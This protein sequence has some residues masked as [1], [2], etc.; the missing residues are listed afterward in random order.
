MFEEFSD[1]AQIWIYGFEEEL[2]AK[3]LKIVENELKNFLEHWKS[4]K[5][6][7]KGDFEILLSRFV[8]LVAES[9]VS[10]C[11]IDKSVSVFKKLRQEHQLNALNQ[12]LVY[13]RN[14]DSVSALSR[15]A[16]QKFV[17][18]DK[19]SWDTIVYN[20]T[21]VMLGVFREGQWELPF[22]KSWHGQ[23]FKKSA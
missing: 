12:D 23:V 22:A 14:K 3:D 6:P 2:S 18:E 5:E 1:Q 13:Y 19:I 4:H 21:P 10:G 9:S 16:F 15:N 8:I 7:V 17:D 20:M 11:S